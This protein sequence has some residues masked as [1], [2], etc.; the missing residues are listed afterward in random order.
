MS[1]RT[2]TRVVNH[3][4]RYCRMQ[5]LLRLMKEFLEKDHMMFRF[6]QE[7]PYTRDILQRW[8]LV[9][10]KLWRLR[11]LY[12]WM[13]WQVK[14]VCLSRQMTI[15]LHVM[16]RRWVKYI[17]LWDWHAHI[18]MVMIL[19]LIRERMMNVKYFIQRISYIPQMV[20][21][22]LTICLIILLRISQIG[23]CVISIM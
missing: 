10:V 6:L 13:P 14:A 22:V 19:I 8:I 15:L 12:I 5:L 20:H 18:L 9:K 11:C 16:V 23:F 2:D 1:L 17:L 3:W 4:I 7:Q 21:L